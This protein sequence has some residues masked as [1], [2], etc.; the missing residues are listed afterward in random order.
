MKSFAALFAKLTG[1]AETPKTLEQARATFGE[2]KAAIDKIAAM[3]TTAALDFDALLTAGENSLR[4]H[5]A[6]ITAKVTTAETAAASASSKVA[7]AD[8][9]TS[10]AEAKVLA[11][12]LQV[13]S[14]NTLLG[15]I[16]FKPSATSKP[17]DLQKAW[18]THIAN[19]VSAKMAELGIKAEKLPP[20]VSAEQ[21]ESAA[22]NL[23]GYDRV[24]AA[25]A[26]PAGKN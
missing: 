14:L 17:E 20:P 21:S 24:R 2:A 18:N 7:D 16:G 23:K 3:F 19:A 26:A 22:K 4:D 8:L 5:I 12:E 15:S 6:A 1:Q 25:F 11:A 13:A 9:K 10:E